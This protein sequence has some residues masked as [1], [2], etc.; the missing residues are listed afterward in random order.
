MSARR[1]RWGIIAY[2][3]F[4]VRGFAGLVQEALRRTVKAVR[5][6][7]PLRRAEPAP[8]DKGRV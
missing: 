2:N 5:R 6:A 1:E 7:L 3:P 8:A 4:S